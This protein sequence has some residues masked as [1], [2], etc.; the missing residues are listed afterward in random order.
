MPRQL[1]KSLDKLGQACFLTLNWNERESRGGSTERV[2]RTWQF[3]CSLPLFAFTINSTSL[4]VYS[5]IWSTETPVGK[6]CN[7]PGLTILVADVCTHDRRAAFMQA[8]ESRHGSPHRGKSELGDDTR[9]PMA[10]GCLVRASFGGGEIV[11]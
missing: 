4:A 2:A 5:P 10:N 9:Q 6:P 1:S 11:L 3:T 7:G 8:T